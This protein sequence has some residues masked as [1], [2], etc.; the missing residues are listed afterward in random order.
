MCEP[1]QNNPTWLPVVALALRN[2]DGRWL[3]HQRPAGKEH[4]GLWEFPGGKVEDG[5]TPTEA[6]VRESAEEL[7]ITIAVHDLDP[8]CFA[9]TSPN[10][11]GLPIV[12]LL[13]ISTIWQGEPRS[14]EG[15][16]VDWFTLEAA[17]ELAKPPLDEHLL[18]QLQRL[19][20]D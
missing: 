14:L 12:I 11:K 2:I 6:L 8:T 9:Q 4:G 10:S 19:H 5:E 20:R 17:G 18:R 1:L 3:L 16:S 7:E 15:G 13:Y